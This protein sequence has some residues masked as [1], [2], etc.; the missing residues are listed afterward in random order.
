MALF[1]AL[2][3]YEF[4]WNPTKQNVHD[5]RRQGIFKGRPLKKGYGPVDGGR[6][7]L[8]DRPQL[9]ESKSNRRNCYLGASNL[10]LI[11]RLRMHHKEV[12]FH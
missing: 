8:L 3:G 10:N 2:Q 1:A 11:L 5:G 4:D 9:L 12:H 7:Y 6:C